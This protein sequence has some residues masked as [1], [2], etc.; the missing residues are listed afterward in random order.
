M[1]RRVE[2]C[3][4]SPVIGVHE[5][6]PVAPG[7]ERSRASASARVAIEAE[8]A[9]R[10]RLEQRAGVA[11]QADRAVHEQTAALRRE[12]ATTSRAITGSC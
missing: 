6:D 12:S 10:A 2:H 5:L 1:P 11:A 7:G 8:H 4:S 9:G 3:G